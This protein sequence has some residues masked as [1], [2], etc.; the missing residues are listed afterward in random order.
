[1]IKNFIYLDAPKMYSLSSQML[2]GVTDY[3]VNESGGEKEETEEQKGP[4]GS[5][6]VIADAIKTSSKSVERKV[7]NDYSFTVFE[8]A[9]SDRGLI[10]EI[11]KPYIGLEE[12]KDKIRVNSFVRVRAKAIFNDI[13]KINEMLASFNEFG[14]DLVTV[15]LHA[16]M[17]EIKS[18]LAALKEAAG[19]DREKKA[20]LEA[21]Q[22]KITNVA[23]IAKDRG[24]YQD[25]K[26]IESM[27]RL[28]KYGFSDQFEIHQ[29]GGE[30]TFTSCLKREFLRESEDLLVKKYSR[31]TEQEI[32][33]IGIVSQAFSPTEVTL[34][35]TEFGNMK[36]AL[37]NVVEHLANVE[38]SISGKDEGEVVID[39]IAA[40][41]EISI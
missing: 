33:V 10:L 38:M 12:L 5:G 17:E 15:T 3:I 32:V 21:E 25:P 29:Y 36:G 6:R 18:E 22:K 34:E 39:P 4:V 41:F 19:N 31:K 9:L 26:F 35:A 7:L 24:L 11:E 28:T 40:Y 37:V 13:N 1:M 23:K 20:R 8:K 14:Q 2:E 30:L 16:E 27:L